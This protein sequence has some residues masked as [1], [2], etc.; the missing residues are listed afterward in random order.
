MTNGV[1][2]VMEELKQVLAAKGFTISGSADCGDNSEEN[3]EGEDGTVPPFNVE[4][5]GDS[6]TTIPHNDA[7]KKIH[8]IAASTTHGA[9]RDVSESKYDNSSRDDNN[10]NDRSKNSHRVVHAR[11]GHTYLQ[12]SSLGVLRDDSSNDDDPRS[13]TLEGRDFVP[14]LAHAW[15]DAGLRAKNYSPTQKW[16]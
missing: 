9:Y 10:N 16:M 13:E 4:S 5:T 12:A 3:E 7:A 1:L 2:A 6:T 11:L 15:T 14:A 8:L